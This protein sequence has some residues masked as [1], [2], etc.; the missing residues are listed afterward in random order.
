M[1]KR[2]VL[3]SIGDFGGQFAPNLTGMTRPIL[4]SGTDGV[5]TK[6]KIAFLLE[7][8]IRDRCYNM[9]KGLLHLL[10]GK[11]TLV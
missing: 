10:Y 8:C 6:L 7:M 1:Y 11:N 5:G 4:V 9:E 2:Q 3:G